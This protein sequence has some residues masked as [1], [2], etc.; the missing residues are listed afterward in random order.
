MSQEEMVDSLQA[1][2]IVSSLGV[3]SGYC[4]GRKIRRCC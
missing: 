1:V 3:W 4:F 2:S